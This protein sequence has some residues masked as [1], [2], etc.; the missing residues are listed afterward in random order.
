M[1]A[2][3]K[4]HGQLWLV[5]LCVAAFLLTYLAPVDASFSDPAG[6]LLTAQ[7]LV[8]HAT[9]RL[10][11]YVAD[12][13]YPYDPLPPAANGHFYDYFPLGTA[14]AAVPAVWLA[15]LRGEDMLYPEDNRA[16]QNALS[17]LTV[18]ACAL[19]IYALCRLYLSLPGSF[20]VTVAFVFGSSIASTLGTALWSSNLA[21]VLGLVVLFLLAR[22]D[23]RR[24]DPP[25]PALGALVALACLCRPTLV[26]LAAGVAAVLCH[27]RRRIP[28]RYLATVGISFAVFALFSWREYG[29]A[30][31]P[32]YQ[33]SRLGGSGRFWQALYGHLA[34]PSRGVLVTSPFL[35][36]T[37]AG[38][39]VWIRRLGRERLVW[40]AVGWIVLHW[41]TVSTFHHWWGGWSFGN[42]LFA[43][44]LPAFLL[45]TV[46]VAREAGH[47]LATPARRLA[48]AAF[49]ATAAFAVF[50]HSHQ[51]L[52]NPYT[53]LWSE[54]IDRDAS[55]VFDWRHPQFLASPATLGIHDRTHR[56]LAMV[57]VS[58]GEPILPT[59]DHVVFEG[60]SIP[61][62]EGAWRWSNGSRARLLFR[63]GEAISSA[64]QLVLEI[65]AGT[66]GPRTIGVTVNGV[67]VGELVSERNWDP[68]IYR[69]TV[70]A[71]AIEAA[72]RPLPGR[73]VFEI[74]LE[75]PGPAPV[76]EGTAQRRLGLCLRRLILTRG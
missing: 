64:R 25:E 74:A 27:R 42:R 11:A 43:E 61:E 30:L 63:A 24:S 39:L 68:A 16:L 12:E 4:R 66:Y 1:E 37:L 36:P 54:G 35:L 19:L 57:A 20:A 13:R 44:V 62:G 72:R 49:A 32:Y 56:L 17:S 8:E 2:Y 40:L 10:D 58:S 33:P 14:L 6:T 71:R 75:I 59:S 31:P 45:L 29:L 28:W 60:W 69:F 47:A 76:G 3:L 48:A 5:A 50:V 23:R 26:W 38:L 51:G 53:V 41:I 73:P 34:S 67:A 65:E 15:R 21:L 22:S 9:I 7:A 70:P 55:R 18:V 52:Y 46:R